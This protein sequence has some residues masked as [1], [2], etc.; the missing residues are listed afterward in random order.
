MNR[1]SLLSSYSIDAS[2]RACHRQTAE[3]CIKVTEDLERYGKA[4][5]A[6]KPE[7]IVECGTNTGMSAVWFAQRIPEVITIELLSDEVTAEL[8]NNVNLIIGSTVDL[9]IINKVTE[10]VGD[11]KCMVTLDSDHSADHVRREIEL[12]GPLVSPGQYLVVE[13]GILRWLP[14]WYIGN[15]L[16]AIETHLIG[17]LGW[18]RDTELEALSPVTLY[19]AGWWV[20]E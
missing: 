18:R 3:G 19:P 11:R 5:A 4:I 13:D 10:I 15:P 9:E 14:S 12:Y 2:L 17:K 7:V 6:T 16:D 1:Q 20:K 8:P